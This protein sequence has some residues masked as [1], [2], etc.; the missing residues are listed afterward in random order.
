LLYPNCDADKVSGMNKLSLAVYCALVG[1]MFGQE[2]PKMMTRV[3][4]TLHSPDAPEGSF[5]AKPKIFYRAADRYC[6]IEEAADPEQGIHN[7]MIINEPDYWAVN[8]LTKTAQH[9]TD[10]G[11]TFNCHLPIF[12]YGNPQ[13]L[14]DETKEIRQLEFG[15]EREFFERKGAIPE[16]GPVL[17]KHETT[18]YKTQVGTASLML[19]LAKSPE[20]PIAVSLKRGDKNEIFIY[21]QYSR[22]EFDPKLFAKPA[23]VR[24]ESSKP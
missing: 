16:P 17:F 12:A 9:G 5:A 15:R 23:D 21:S 10:P 14:D 19:F 24:I 8:L 6:R 4:V 20:L 11:P 2:P 13:S 7:L 22:M 1:M 3:E 18:A